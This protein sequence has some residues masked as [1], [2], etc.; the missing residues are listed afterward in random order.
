MSGEEESTDDEQGDEEQ[1]VNREKNKDD[2]KSIDNLIEQG[3]NANLRILSKEQIG[4]AVEI[5]DTNKCLHPTTTT[6]NVD[7]RGVEDSNVFGRTGM[8]D[9]EVSN[10]GHTNDL[11]KQ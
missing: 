11:K 8:H 2:L 5:I 1:S 3:E 10:A 7:N 9:T 4:Q 6:H